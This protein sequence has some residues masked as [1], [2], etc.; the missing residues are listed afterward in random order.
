MHIDSSSPP[1]FKYTTAAD[2]ARLGAWLADA[3][4]GSGPL[5]RYG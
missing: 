4:A 1:S 5:V 2:M 3:A